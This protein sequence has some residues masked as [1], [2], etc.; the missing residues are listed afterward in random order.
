MARDTSTARKY[1]IDQDQSTLYVDG[2][3]HIIVDWP[4]VD[5]AN[6]GRLI[7]PL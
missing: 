7:G 5:T 1:F 3:Y 6:F 4:A 2:G